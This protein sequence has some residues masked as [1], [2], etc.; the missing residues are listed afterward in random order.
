MAAAVSAGVM[1]NGCLGNA[2]CGCGVAMPYPDVCPS[3]PVLTDVVCPSG[4]RIPDCYSCDIATQFNETDET[5]TGYCRVDRNTGVPQFVPAPIHFNS[6]V[7]CRVQI[8]PTTT[9]TTTATT[10]MLANT[11]PTAHPVTWPALA[12]IVA[13]GSSSRKIYAARPRLDSK[14]MSAPGAG[15]RV[16]ECRA[17]TLRPRADFAV[18]PGGSA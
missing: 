18:G 15:K 6:D 4:S 2:T 12:A 3:C 17:S 16:T 14:S 13:P 5:T 11:E 8:A 9:T 7:V 1:Q 10:T